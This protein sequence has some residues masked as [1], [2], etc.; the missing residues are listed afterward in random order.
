M[1]Q[2][3]RHVRDSEL[4]V[5]QQCHIRGQRLGGGI[6][7]RGYDAVSAFATLLTNC[8]IAANQ[9]SQNAGG[10]CFRDVCNLTM[11]DC[12]IE[13]NTANGLPT[14][15]RGAGIYFYPSLAG[16]RMN[17]FMLGCQVKNNTCVDA[18]GGIYSSNND[19]DLLMRNC[20]VA[21][22][23]C[24][25]SG[26]GMHLYGQLFMTNCIIGDNLATGNASYGSGLYCQPGMPRVQLYNT[27]FHGNRGVRGGALRTGNLATGIYH[28]VNCT[29]VSNYSELESSAGVRVIGDAAEV[30]IRNSVL[31]HNERAGLA[32][33][34]YLPIMA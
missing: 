25:N 13:Q 12:R 4:R 34:Y 14:Q 7:A 23:E 31:Y 16:I 20:L 15:G 8:V 27:L 30:V 26:A 28:F 21:G 11:V 19:L 33:N 10:I 22:N 9:A 29:V 6:H 3:C 24:V 1:V 5:Q 18:G 32:N 2:A 17:V